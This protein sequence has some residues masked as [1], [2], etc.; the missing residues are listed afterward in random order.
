MEEYLFVSIALLLIGLMLAYLLWPLL[1][2]TRKSALVKTAQVLG[3]TCFA[4]LFGLSLPSEYFSGNPVLSYLWGAV[5]ILGCV[6]VVLT[7]RAL[8]R[9]FWRPNDRP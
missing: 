7:L 5:R 6:V 3:A 1:A 8:I 9:D 4:L 2:L